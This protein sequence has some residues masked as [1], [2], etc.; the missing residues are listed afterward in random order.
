MYEAA[1]LALDTTSDGAG[2]GEITVGCLFQQE[3]F[4]CCAY[5]IGLFVETRLPVYR[6]GARLV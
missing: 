1:Y 4:R 6:P 2:V 3:I 5:R